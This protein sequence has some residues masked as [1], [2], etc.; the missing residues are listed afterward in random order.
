[1][2]PTFNQTV[3]VLVQ[4]YLNDT[5]EHINGCACAVGNLV[6]A[7]NGYTFKTAPAEYLDTSIVWAES[8]YPSNGNGWLDARLGKPS[9]KALE[10]I[11]STGYTA[12]EIFRIEKAFESPYQ[13]RNHYML[14][15]DEVMFQGL[16]NVVDVLSEIHETTLEQKEQA[17]LLFA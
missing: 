9:G 15:K 4:A 16:M 12:E 2:R 5:L 3:N 7:A 8:N 11:N 10:Q 13:T 14:N 1:M 17:K 6:A